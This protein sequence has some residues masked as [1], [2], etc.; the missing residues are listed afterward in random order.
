MIVLQ[1]LAINRIIFYLVAEAFL[2]KTYMLLYQPG[3]GPFSM[4]AL[5]VAYTVTNVYVKQSWIV[6]EFIAI[7]D[8]IDGT[9]E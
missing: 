1:T 8:T 5:I 7:D 3:T 2:F 9:F 4:I 6:G